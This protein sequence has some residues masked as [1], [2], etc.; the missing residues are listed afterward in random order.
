MAWRGTALLVQPWPA[1]LAGTRRSRVWQD[2][3]LIDIVESVFPEQAAGTGLTMIA[4][5]RD[6]QV[7]PPGRMQVAAKDQVVVQSANSHIDWAAARKITLAMAGGASLVIGGGDIVAQCPGTLTVRAGM[8]SFLGPQGQP[9]AM[10]QMP[11]SVHVC[12]ECLLNALR[13]GS[14]LAVV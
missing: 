6:V 14:A 3:S 11:A 2:R 8:K 12:K 1:L 9:Y 13:A 4:A 7:Q 5:Q 10:P